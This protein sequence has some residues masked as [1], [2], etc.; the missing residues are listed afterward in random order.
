M[1]TKD[2]AVRYEKLLE[3]TK[4]EGPV[5]PV[6]AARSWLNRIYKV[7]R[8]QQRYERQKRETGVVILFFECD[9]PLTEADDQALRRAAAL[10]RQIG[11]ELKAMREALPVTRH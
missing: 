4:E 11:R 8:L 10:N 5:P 3:K 9:R 2:L 7:F 1:E 6:F